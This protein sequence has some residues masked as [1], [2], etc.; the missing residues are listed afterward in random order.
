MENISEKFKDYRAGDI[1]RVGWDRGNGNLESEFFYYG[2]NPLDNQPLLVDL[3]NM[4]KK[5]VIF[6]NQEDKIQDVSCT[7]RYSPLYDNSCDPRVR[8]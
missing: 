2:V 7:L 8:F 3:K 5:P 1:L 6:F 4:G